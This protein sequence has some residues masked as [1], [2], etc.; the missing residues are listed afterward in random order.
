MSLP[1]LGDVNWVDLVGLV[2]VLAYGI[3]GLLK[4]AIR[5][6]VGLAAVVVGLILAGTFGESLGARDWPFIADSQDS[7][8]IGVLVGC[9]L[10]FVGTLLVGALVAKLLR[11]AAEETDLGGVDRF[12]GLVFG[13]LRGTLYVTL[14]VTLLMFVHGLFPDMRSLHDALEG[15]WGL[16][17]TR[18]VADVCGG[19]FPPPMAE[20]LDET[21]V[22]TS[23]DGMPP[24]PP[25]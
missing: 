6:I 21:L 14:A 11:A 17:V 8:R 9:G 24:P 13:V 25:R 19:W 10:L 20:W 5:F 4:G 15:S 1:T 3:A 16:E 22:L 12:L 18:T 7:Q 2:V 23:P